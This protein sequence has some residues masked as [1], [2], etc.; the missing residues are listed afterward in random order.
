[1]QSVTQIKSTGAI[2]DGDAFELPTGVAKLAVGGEWRSES[3]ARGTAA[4]HQFDRTVESAFAELAVP[5]IGRADDPRAVPRLE[6]SLAARYEQYSDFGSTSNPKIGL[7]WA[8]SSS[9]KLRTSW[10]T[11]FKAPKLADVYDSS[12][13]LAGLASLKDPRSA[14]G[15]SVVLV[16]QGSNPHL[17]QE[18]ASTWTAG[19]DFAP[20][21]VDGLALSLTY[22]S[23]GYNHRILVPGP[24]SPT[25]VLLQEAQW[26]S[27]INRNVTP[28]EINA[29]CESAV[30]SGSAAQCGSA[31]VAAIVDLRV[32]NMAETRVRGVD[33]KLDQTLRT[34]R[35]R[36]D[37]GLNGG[38][39]LSFWQ[40]SSDTSPLK[41]VVNTVGNPLALRMRGTVDW[42]QR[43]WDKP[44][45]GASAVVDYFG[46]YSDPHATTIRSVDALATVDLRFSYRTARGSGAFDGLEFG[47]NG[48]NVFNESPPFV[49][50]D[51][52]YDQINAQPFGRVLSFTIQKSW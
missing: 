19:V 37:F 50:R 15:S 52:G 23:I 24:S 10:G 49:N 13:D 41:N 51:T 6:L 38:Y 16:L 39:V 11:S 4:L 1:L 3:L 40:A 7:R 22:Y 20:S 43:D 28:A 26:A 46:G 44:G 12:N 5:L 25:D 47:L 48:V 8:P 2:A 27:V 36:F 14:S 32:R 31:P 33:L 45:F 35:G 21:S 9:V 29:V 17:E 18:R 34:R 30:F 42:Y